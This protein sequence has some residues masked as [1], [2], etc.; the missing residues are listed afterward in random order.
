MAAFVGMRY[1]S[2]LKTFFA[3]LK[4]QGKP[5]KVALT[6][7]MRKLLTILNTLVRTGQMWNVEASSSS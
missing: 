5:S 3:R 1:N 7:C 2:K 4:Q 6:A